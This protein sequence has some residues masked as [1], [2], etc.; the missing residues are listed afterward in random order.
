MKPYLLIFSATVL[1]AQFQPVSPIYKSIPRAHKLWIQGDY[2][3]SL[4]AFEARPVNPDNLYNRAF[5]HHFLG[6]YDQ[7]EA[8]LKQLFEKSNDHS[9]S[10][11]LMGRLKHQKKDLTGAM[12]SLERAIAIDEHAPFYLELGTVYFE[13]KQYQ[14]AFDAFEGALDG[15]A[16]MMAA[17]IYM[18][19]I[20]QAQNRIPDAIEIL[21]EAYPNQFAEGEFDPLLGSLYEANKQPQKAI[22]TYKRYL[23]FY[24]FGRFEKDIKSRLNRLGV[25]SFKPVFDPASLSKNYRISPKER[26][27]Y[28]VRYGFSL[29]TMEI[30]VGDSILKRKQDELIKLTYKLRS[31][32]FLIELTSDF[33]GF[34]NTKTFMPMFSYLCNETDDDINE[35]RRYDYDYKNLRF[36]SRIVQSGGR[37]DYTGKELP[38]NA[39]DGMAILFYARALVANKVSQVVTTIID[40]YYKRTDVKVEG[41]VVNDEV[42]NQERQMY[43]LFAAVHYEG[44][45]G[46]QGN[47]EGFFLTDG[48]VPAIGLLELIVGNVRVQLIEHTKGV[49]P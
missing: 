35:I 26:L 10:H 34:I 48:M 41:K 38:H 2:R 3:A 20:R 14:R 16:N 42:M 11:Y 31:T 49:N 7:A 46:I 43:Y 37:L 21:E 8:V 27:L 4:K 6:E 18:A 23:Y 13:Q 36:S 1:A 12:R 15:N 17:Y 47:A 30:V 33:E 29:G 19:K 9:W 39:H 40:E 45:A 25:K 5:L 24:P 32:S 28:D 44:I 22:Q